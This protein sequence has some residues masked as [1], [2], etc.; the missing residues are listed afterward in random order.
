MNPVGQW[1]VVW[2]RWLWSILLLMIWVVPATISAGVTDIS[3][4]T[5]ESTLDAEISV[6]T[7]LVEPTLA[8]FSTAFA[9]PPR[10]L[11]SRPLWFWNTPEIT[12][13]KIE[14]I[15]RHSAEESGYAGFGILPSFGPTNNFSA[16]NVYL[17]EEY[18]SYYRV[19]IESAK[20]YGV[21]LCLYDEYW[22]PSGAAGGVLRERFPEAV[23]QELI[24]EEENLEI[25]GNDD[26]KAKVPLLTEG[27]S[28]PEETLMARVAIHSV[29]GTRIGLSRV[30]VGPSSESFVILPPGSWRILTFYCRPSPQPLVDYLNAAAVKR[31]IEL[32]HDAYYARFAEY[33]GTTI[34]SVFY[35]EPPLY[36]VNTWTPSFN[37]KFREKYGESSD[38]TLLY[39]DLFFDLDDSTPRAR[40]ML[41]GLRS[42]LFATAYI[43]Q[44]DQW[45]REHRVQL[46]GHMDQEQIQNPTATCGDLLYCFR[47]QEIP[48]ID[49]IGH[50]GRTQNAYKLISSAAVNWDRTQVMSETYGAITGMPVRDLYRIAMDE[51]A[52]GVNLLVPHAVWLSNDPKRV[53]FE[54]E[55]SWRNAQYGP[56]LPAFNQY[57]GRLNLLLQRGFP[58]ADIAVFYPIATLHAGYRFGEG[59]AYQGGAIVPE[60]D[61]QTIGEN[62]SLHNRHDFTYLHPETLRERCVIDGNQ[63]RLTNTRNPQSYQT[64]ILPGM[65]IVDVASLR[66]AKAFYDAGGR[67]I[68]TTRLP[69]RSI[70]PEGDAEVRQLATAI[71]GT[72]AE[73]RASSS[74]EKREKLPVSEST[75]AWSVTT[76]AAGGVAIFLPSPTPEVLE[77]ALTVKPDTQGA[78]SKVAVYDVEFTDRPAVAGGNLTYLH[79]T[80]P[81]MEVYF[82]ANS[83]ETEVETT[84]VLRNPERFGAEMRLERWN[85][86]TGEQSALDSKPTTTSP[87]TSPPDTHTVRTT[88]FTLQLPP[89][90][91]VFVIGS[92]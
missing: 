91:S 42:E 92:R 53:T 51:Y 75:S 54:P 14:E 71:F 38:P 80:L 65:K 1:N 41:F 25:V 33:F 63:L 22:F 70:E 56:E 52:K 23:M 2:M 67:V 62:L 55:L 45:C 4:N 29:D 83:S 77:M 73:T 44:M 84:V 6:N 89:F 18:F 9:H 74:D 3:A 66:Q 12:A 19:A 88:Q 49:E 34:D 32:T 76:N 31:F 50:F 39:P 16:Q 86:H 30:S 5:M 17:T 57:V 24:C 72:D 37:E 87:S 59:D 69:S 48:G 8:D 7:E 90:T 40:A 82:F 68:A 46:T 58:V 11:H 43:G 15:T 10:E 27:T 64:L 20:K 47:H 21:K 13:E 61:Y 35:D 26:P 78:L 60:A 85:P 36:R 28:S 79:K 81:E